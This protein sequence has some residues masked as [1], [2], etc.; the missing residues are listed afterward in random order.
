MGKPNHTKKWSFKP[1]DKSEKPVVGWNTA[2]DEKLILNIKR[3]TWDQFSFEEQVF[4]QVSYVYI[5][6]FHSI[7]NIAN[8]ISYH[9]ISINI[10]Q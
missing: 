2:K 3:K 10:N 7:L 1:K 5:Y 9:S 6:Y 4:S 8:K